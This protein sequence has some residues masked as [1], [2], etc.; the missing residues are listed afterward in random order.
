MADSASHLLQFIIEHHLYSLPLDGNQ[1]S[2][3]SC[4][5][6]TASFLFLAML[7]WRLFSPDHLMTLGASQQAGGGESV[8]NAL[9][10]LNKPYCTFTPKAVIDAKS[11]NSSKRDAV[12]NIS[13][14]LIAHHVNHLNVA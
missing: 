2:G 7:I 5:E 1:G 10:K 4:W 13:I 9:E 8:L 11:Q 3:V 12:Q 14:A 6:S